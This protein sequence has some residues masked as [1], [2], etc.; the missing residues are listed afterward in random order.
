M[1][2]Q[3]RNPA[4]SAPDPQ[5][6]FGSTG[7][8][9]PIQILVLCL[10]NCCAY[11]NIMRYATMGFQTSSKALKR[12]WISHKLFMI[13]YLRDCGILGSTK[14]SHYISR[15]I[16]IKFIYHFLENYYLR[17]I[18]KLSFRWNVYESVRTESPL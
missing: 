5:H 18:N 10:S 16:V 14:R 9:T 17:V 6:Y 12:D 13:I 3:L 2:W 15:T 8:A 4:I 11:S 1:D 7:P